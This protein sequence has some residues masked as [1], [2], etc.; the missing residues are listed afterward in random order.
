MQLST[1]IRGLTLETLTED[2]S[3]AYYEV[4]DRNR[5]HLTACGDYQELGDATLESVADD[6]RENPERAL[7]CGIWLKGELVGRVDLVPREGTNFVLGYW[8][9][10]RHT[11]QRVR[12]SCMLLGDPIRA[13]DRGNGHLGGCHEGEQ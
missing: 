3:D 5:R 10:E 7:R 9:D 4:V 6:L 1:E 12:N 13:A 11:P 8:L 2:H